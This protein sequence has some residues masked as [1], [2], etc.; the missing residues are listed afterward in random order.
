MPTQ[1]D[2][3]LMENYSS[4]SQNRGEKNHFREVSV[5]AK[6][7][8][9]DVSSECAEVSRGEEGKITTHRGRAV[10]RIKNQEC[11]SPR[12]QAGRAGC[13]AERAPTPAF[14]G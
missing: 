3:L 11:S 12:A 14:S 10:D 8:C 1:S 13:P 5:K 7:A 2:V 4:A 9:D 6:F